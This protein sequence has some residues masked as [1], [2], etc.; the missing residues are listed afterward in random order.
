MHHHRPPARG[1]GQPI[2]ISIALQPMPWLFKSRS[3][4][5]DW[6]FPAWLAGRLSGWQR[7][8]PGVLRSAWLL[9]PQAPLESITA[10]GRM[11]SESRW[12]SVRAVAPFRSPI[13]YSALR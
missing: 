3:P 9:P 12:T 2:L 4:Q 13:I 10:S 11:V 8:D 7:E 6:G 1:F 5:E